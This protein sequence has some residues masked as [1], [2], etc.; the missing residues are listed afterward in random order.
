MKV[1]MPQ[2]GET[3]EEGTIVEWF[4]KPGEDIK[5]DDVLFE[6]E[7]DKVTTEVPSTVDGVLSKVLVGEGETVPV[8]AVL[9]VI[10]VEGE[11]EE[12]DEAADEA[13]ASPPKPEAGSD[14]ERTISPRE[15]RKAG[16]R[17]QK[18]SPVVKR[19]LAEH[20]LDASQVAGTG[21]GGRITRKDVLAFVESGGEGVSDDET[22]EPF[23]TVRK[24]TGDHMVRSKATSPHVLQAVEVDF[25]AVDDLRAAEGEDWKASAGYTLTYLPFVARAVCLAIR[26]FP[27]INASVADGGLRVHAVINLAIAVDLGF[28]GLVAPVIKD[29]GEKTLR[30]LAEAAHDLAEK[31]R[32]NGLSPDEMSGGTYTISN[33]GSFGT[34][35]TYPIINQPQVAILSMDGVR[36]KP[37]VVETDGG[38][39]IVVRPVGVLAQSFDHRAFDGAYSAAFLSRLR[40]LLETT[41]WAAELN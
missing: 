12:E 3:V 10:T 36:K 25:E 7:T 33:S 8:G 17:D 26:E 37:V 28:E 5:K 31:A 22:L 35:F 24:R 30:E 16:G 29:A 41:D 34:F 2:L 14:S 4:K 11:A 32:S 15:P 39:E 21:D 9:A 20:G 18:L 19:L 40:E 27:K 13:E 1:L 23:N 6:V 38:D